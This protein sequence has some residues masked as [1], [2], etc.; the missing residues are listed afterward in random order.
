M[1]SIDSLKLYAIKFKNNIDAK[2]HTQDYYA[3]KED[4][5]L[6]KYIFE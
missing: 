2:K 1:S 4:L 5:V 6:Q 3:D